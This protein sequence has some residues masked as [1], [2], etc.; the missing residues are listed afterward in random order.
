MAPHVIHRPEDEDDRRPRGRPIPREEDAVD[1]VPFVPWQ[2]RSCGSKKTFTYGQRGRTR[3]H[4]CRECGLCYRSI[5]LP[6]DEIR[7]P[8]L[9]STN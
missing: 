7:H 3:Y 9:P 5:E 8:S 4:E 2:C 1:V 6:P